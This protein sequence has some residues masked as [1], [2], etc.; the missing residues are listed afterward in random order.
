MSRETERKLI[1]DHF[2]L[3]WD[4]ADGPVAYPNQEFNTPANSMF[5]VVH[6][7]EGM[8]TRKSIGYSQYLK[9]ATGT[10]Q[11]DIYAPSGSGT[12]TSRIIGERLERIY[13]TLDLVTSDGERVCFLTPRSRTVPINEQRAANLDDN[14]DR[15]V[16]EAPFFR[17]IEVTK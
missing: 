16:V 13:D 8:T 12:K 15:Y 6:I 10:L 17:D 1:I 11:I 2:K 9:R 3:N 5:A 14:W 7:V 4:P